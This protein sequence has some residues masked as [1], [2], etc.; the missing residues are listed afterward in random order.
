LIP[1]LPDSESD[2]PLSSFCVFALLRFFLALPLISAP[3]FVYSLLRSHANVSLV[4]ANRSGR[5]AFGCSRIVLFVFRAPFL[6]LLFGFSHFIPCRFCE[7]FFSITLTS[8]FFPYVHPHLRISC[9]P[10]RDKVISGTFPFSS[11]RFLGMVSS[12]QVLH[13]VP[14]GYLF[15]LLALGLRRFPSTGAFSGFVRGDVCFS[16][17]VSCLVLPP[18]VRYFLFLYV[19]FCSR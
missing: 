2:F 19:C 17:G 1:F 15:L 16:F 9:N 10:F 18:S 11:Y 4:Q 5:L 8:L 13:V 7:C 3:F 14:C 12:L 6:V